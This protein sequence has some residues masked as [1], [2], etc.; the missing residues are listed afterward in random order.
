MAGDTFRVTIDDRELQRILRETPGKADDLIEGLARE[1]Q[2]L[3]MRSFNTSPPGQT[4]RRGRVA[5]VASVAGYPP[6]I[7]TGKLMNAIYIY[8]PRALQ[9]MIST[10][11]T[12]YAAMLEFGTS[13][14]AAR[15][16]MRPMVEELRKIAP[17]VFDRLI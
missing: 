3:V 2:A 4:Y 16:F 5:H 8:K 10:G 7:D 6:N 12:D 1:G 13:K 14:M 15:P 9:R 17:E 11:D